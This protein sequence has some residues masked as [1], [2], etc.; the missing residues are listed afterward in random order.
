V[1]SPPSSS[2]LP[3]TIALPRGG[4][5]VVRQS[6]PGDAVAL[7][8][9]YDGLSLDDRY[10]RFFSGSLPPD[11]AERWAALG[12]RGG[13]G[14]VAVIANGEEH[15]VAEAGF[16]VLADGDGEFAI[17]V[18]RE[19]R[20]WLGAYLL[21]VLVEEAARRGVRNL[22]AEIL[23]EN[24]AMLALVRSRGYAV[25]DDD[26][27][28]SVRVTISTTGSTPDWPE[29][30][31]RPRVLV[32]APG[33]RWSSAGDAQ[34]RGMQVITCPGPERAPPGG[35]PALE[36]RPCPLAAHADVIVFAFPP[37]DPRAQ[38]LLAAHPRLHEAVP[39]VVAPPASGASFVVP[40]GATPVAC[41]PAAE[42]IELVSALAARRHEDAV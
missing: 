37:S 42:V 1:G 21:D 35:C 20:G 14:L 2:S 39:L 12:E 26:D 9:L 3:R 7:Q 34:T 5:L 22:R 16:G 40:E 17:T 11:F 38:A 23:V 10:R 36:G 13:V 30:D 4:S 31:D 32:E 41:T 25:L 19:W 27:W 15:I 28:S 18:S 6:D 29:V 8:Q 24:T 33:G